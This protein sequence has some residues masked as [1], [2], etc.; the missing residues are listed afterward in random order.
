MGILLLCI[1]AFVLNQMFSFKVGEKILSA[2]FIFLI[3]DLKIFQNDRP[4]NG[5]GRVGV[6]K[7]S[8]VRTGQNE[9]N[10][11]YLEGFSTF[12]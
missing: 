11:I 7:Y 6:A 12:P 9:G 5:N 10:K 3:S 1:F 8:S 2:S 4:K